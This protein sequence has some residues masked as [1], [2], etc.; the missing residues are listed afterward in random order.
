MINNNNY[1]V[2]DDNLPI[3]FD[4]IKNHLLVEQFSNLSS[5]KLVNDF[6]SNSIDDIIDI[7][8]LRACLVLLDDISV[9]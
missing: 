6:D 8:Y 7:S 5:L 4:D 2:F 3:S 1:I 9:K